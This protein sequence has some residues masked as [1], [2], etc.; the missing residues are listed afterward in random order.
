MS[1]DPAVTARALIDVPRIRRSIR[2]HKFLRRRLK[3][4]HALVDRLVR[5]LKIGRNPRD[6]QRRRRAFADFACP[7]GA[8]Q[9]VPRDRGYLLLG[10]GALRQQDRAAEVAAAAFR[11]FH[12]DGTLSRALADTNKRFLVNVLRDAAFIAHPEVLRFATARPVIDM[13]ARYL[14]CIPVL[15]T[16]RLWWTPAN[17]S[18]ESSQLFHRDAEGS[19]QLKVFVNVTEV[20][21]ASGPLTIIPANRSEPIMEQLRYRRGKLDDATVDACGGLDGVIALTGQSGSAAAVDTTRCLHLGS[22]GNTE[23]RVVLML[24]YTP[25][26]APRGAAPSWRNVVSGFANELDE[27]QRMVLN[28]R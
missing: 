19:E 10:S 20:T 14:G 27:V 22:R 12:N 21:E 25:S 3:L 1:Y 26:W 24:Q 11:S 13:V 2:I 7:T 18:R 9:I 28:L 4:P 17:D 15:A 8:D 6:H 23:D 16:V 5:I